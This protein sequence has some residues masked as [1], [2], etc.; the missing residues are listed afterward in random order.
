M[1]RSITALEMVSTICMVAVAFITLLLALFA[2]RAG[3]LDPCETEDK[4]SS[5]CPSDHELFVTNYSTLRVFSIFISAFSCHASIFPIAAEL[6]APTPRR[7]DAVIGLAI[8]T[9]FV[10]YMVALSG[11]EAFGRDVDPN[12]F[13]TF[14]GMHA[15]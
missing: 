7:L 6:I 8:G 3:D 10:V 1:F 14:P 11:Y 9:A 4:L 2:L 12:I 13:V 15:A 5:E